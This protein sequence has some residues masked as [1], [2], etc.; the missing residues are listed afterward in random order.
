VPA[1]E[2]TLLR[3]GH[4][5]TGQK[6]LPATPEGHGP[7]C[8]KLDTRGIR[9]HFAHVMQQMVQLAGPDAGSVFHTFFVDSWEAGGQNWT[10]KM[11]EEFRRRRGYDVIPFLPILTGRVIDDLQTSERFLYDL[12]LTVSE[13][14]TE[15]FWAE[16]QRLCHAHGM[17]IAVEPYI[18]TGQDLDAANFTDEPMGEFWAI[19]NTTTDYRQTVKL[20]SSAANLNGH[21]IVGVEAFTSTAG[22]KWQSHPATLKALGDQILCLG[23]NRFQFHRFAMQRFPQLQPGMMMGGWGQQYD[24]TQTWWEWT[25]PW[26][27]Y[28]ARCQLLLREGPVVAD[29]LAIAPEEPL[30]RFE[31]SVIPGYDYD[32]C[33]PDVFRRA[34]V[35]GGVVVLPHDRRYRLM[36]LRQ[37]D[38]MSVA[39]LRHLVD[40]VA[41]GAILLGEPPRA[42]PGL[43]EGPGADLELHQLVEALWGV[44]Q[45]PERVFGLGRVFRGVPPEVILTRRGLLPDFESSV[46]LSWIHRTSPQAEIYFVASASGEAVEAR[47]TFRVKGRAAELWE[48]ETGRRRP[49]A[50][51][52]TPDGRTSV[53]LSLGPTESVFVVFPVAPQA[54]VSSVAVA[55]VAEPAARPNGGTRTRQELA[56]PWTIAFPAGSG[57][58]ERLTVDRLFAWNQHGDSEIRHFSGAAVYHHSFTVSSPH[59]RVELDL[60]RVEVMARVVLNG[61]DLGILWKPPYRVDITDA[62][63]PGSNML[64]VAVVNLWVNRLIGD[65]GLPEDAERDKGGRLVAWPEWVLE[66]RTSPTGRRTFVT[67]PLW[68]TGDPLKDSGLL[69][70]ATLL[71]SSAAERG[72]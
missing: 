18:T 55:S 2:W 29:V 47:C 10:E 43:A 16:M 41:A 35:E 62:L 3:F 7:E 69:G 23:A 34:R 14:V 42:V 19:P 1:G 15:N 72:P 11:P 20:A 68:K 44:A 48:P 38:T 71:F 22:E 39:R 51:T 49:L 57:A 13:L 26:H 67:F 25:R 59:G 66:G 45:E 61:R 53:N 8:D 6:T 5:W 17:R 36:V 58:P 52:A 50:S 70:P 40:L 46:P 27:D 33:G 4:T 64:E 30:E 32:G 28:L 21:R 24:S 12:R 31:A 63:Q 56:G 37:T 54:S 60:G 9:A 65:A